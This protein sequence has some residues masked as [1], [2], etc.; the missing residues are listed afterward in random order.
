MRRLSVPCILM[1]VSLSSPS[2]WTLAA[3]ACAFPFMAWADAPS[4]TLL[5]T[6]AGQAVTLATPTTNATPSDIDRDGVH[7]QAQRLIGAFSGDQE[8][9]RI[10][11]TARGGDPG[12]NVSPEEKARYRA[13]IEAIL[14]PVSNTRLRDLDHYLNTHAGVRA[15]VPIKSTDGW[16]T[17]TTKYVG[18]E[19][20]GVGATVVTLGYS[21]VKW[22]DQTTGTDLGWW[23][24]QDFHNP[25][26]SR[27]SWGEAWD[28]I[29][30]TWVGVYN[31]KR[32]S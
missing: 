10:V 15:T 23:A 21:G 12:W 24:G 6:P 3:L 31:P 11:I 16:F 30:G 2:V 25:N 28:G 13:K 7:A 29:R 32:R 1:N 8:A 26:T 17:R 9:L 20:V 4:L 27:A 14:G 19:L 5:G 22:V 18:R